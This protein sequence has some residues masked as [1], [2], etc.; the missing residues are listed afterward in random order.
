MQKRRRYGRAKGVL[1]GI[2]F[3]AMGCARREAIERYNKAVHF[4]EARQ[5]A[6]AIVELETALKLHPHFPEAHNT[7]GYVLNANG[8]YEEAIEHFRQAA[9]NPKFKQRA[10]AYTNLGAAY[11]NARQYTHA[12]NALKKALE[13][14]ESASTHYTLAQIYAA[15]EKN[16]LA[17]EALAK[18]LALESQRVYEMDRD[19][20][21]DNLRDTPQYKALITKYWK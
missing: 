3:V 10:L 11:T 2:V 16:N 9:E 20:L 12:E 13:L 7:L 8:R 14:N 4:I 17:L 5:Y 6:E 1:L 21:F 18:A 19:P 15:Q